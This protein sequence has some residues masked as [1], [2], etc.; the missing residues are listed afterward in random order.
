MRDQEEACINGHHKLYWV[1]EHT[2]LAALV[3]PMTNGLS[4]L[5]NSGMTKFAGLTIK[6]LSSMN[7]YMVS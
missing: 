6:D 1:N 5:C 2:A 4:K 7:K 3:N